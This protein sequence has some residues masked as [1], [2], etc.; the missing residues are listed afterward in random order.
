M[1]DIDEKRMPTG[2]VDERLRELHRD[3]DEFPQ[4]EEEEDIMGCR[5]ASTWVL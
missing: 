4:V 3:A 1:D 5:L 2:H